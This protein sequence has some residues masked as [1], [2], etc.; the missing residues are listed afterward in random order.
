MPLFCRKHQKDGYKNYKKQ[1]AKKNNK[2]KEAAVQS[3]KK[4]SLSAKDLFE[5]G[6]TSLADLL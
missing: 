5:V 3:K 2:K 6:K 4:R 1:S